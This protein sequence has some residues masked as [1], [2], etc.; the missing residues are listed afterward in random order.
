MKRYKF[1][2]A[3]S[4]LLVSSS[5]IAEV[6]PISTTVDGY[7]TRGVEMFERENYLGCI[8]QLTFAQGMAITDKLAEKSALYIAMA[9]YQL[10]SSL[11]EVLLEG[12]IADYPYSL[13]KSIAQFYLGNC[14]FY[15][16]KFGEAAVNYLTVNGDMLTQAERMDM[17][18][19]LGYSLLRIGESAEAGTY[20]QR[21]ANSTKYKDVSIFY[22]AYLDYLNKDYTTALDKFNRVN[23]NSPL[24]LDS[25][26]YTTQIY[27]LQGDYSKALTYGTSM[28]ERESGSNM[29]RA[30]MHRVVG[31]SEYQLGN[32]TNA[33][34]NIQ[35]YLSTTEGDEERSA[36]YL[37]GVLNFR[38]MDYQATIDN[39]AKVTSEDGDAM[40]QSAYVFIGQSYLKLEKM[41][42]ASIA[43]EKAFNIS[44]D[45]Q[46]QEIAFYNYALSQQAGGRTPFNKAVE[47][48]EQ[49]RK[50]FPDSKYNAEIDEYIAN[51]YMNDKDYASAFASI[52]K[53]DNP[54]ENVLKVK[55]YIM[56]K[57]AI[58]SATNGD[59]DRALE[60]FNGVKKL[61]AQNPTLANETNL[62]IG[63]IAYANDEYAKAEGCYI[64]YLKSAIDSNKAI[65]Y[66]NLGYVQYQ[67]KD[68]AA[69]R[70]SF[71]NAV[72]A[73][74]KLPAAETADANNRIGDCCYY[75]Q[76]YSL[77]YSYYT[78]GA[79]SDKAGDY[80]LYQMAIIDGLQKKH[81][82]KIKG[83]DKML[84]R[85]PESTLAPKALLEQA[86]A[87]IALNKGVEGINVF[88]KVVTNYPSTIEA[89]KAMLQL[90]ITAKNVGDETTA[91]KY[92][93][94]VISEYP[95]SDEAAVAI[96]D[97][98]IIYA[99]KNNID[100]LNSFLTQVPN[101]PSISVTEAD[102]LTF[103]A[104]EKSYI[105]NPKEITKLKE[106]VADFKNGAFVANAQYYIA[107]YN[108]TNSDYDEALKGINIVLSMAKDASFAED[109]L[110]M[111]CEIL[112]KSGDTQELLK[113]YKELEV[114]ASTNDNRIVA[115]LGVMR[116]AKIM[117]Y[118]QD[119]VD[120]TT[121]LL[122]FSGLTA[123]E[124]KEVYM[125]RA[126]SYISLDQKSK[127]IE[128]LSKLA[129]ETQSIYGV[130]GAYTLAELSFDEQDYDK[131]EAQL[132][133]IINK[134]TPHQYWLARSFILLSDVYSAKGNS[135]EAKE[136]LESLKSNY[137][138]N[139]TEIFSMIEERLT[140]LK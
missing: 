11:K 27:F 20:F 18:F 28:L 115:N 64:Q 39:M 83:I 2:V 109:A 19:R 47:I 24:S 26:Y 12:F 6:S 138:G 123:D 126:L 131:A 21:I 57:L 136:Y 56:Y 68:Y 42:S 100:E 130:K 55:Q 112:T 95:S 76:E 54:S 96:E 118:N 25:R 34:E 92:Y 84:E 15:K 98:K 17:N 29:M 4:L 23:S 91:I 77:A 81:A 121:K 32:D 35:S 103:L 110:A 99:E 33:M 90:A 75:T 85:F 70:K 41:N 53:I 128:D 7:V 71:Y 48:F 59:N 31:E 113:L 120:S 94:E 111:K 114:K 38:R 134:G 60:L 125:N 97:L 117:D 65:A 104:A 73:K 66:Y 127:A 10:G 51:V 87:Y 124:E 102:K 16:G 30:E 106:Y 9:E 108:Y 5:A 13:N 135:F 132:D 88:R 50:N 74:V 93:K 44:Y 129:Q 45:K 79:D 37:L 14:Y 8:D 107:K 119:V 67:Q 58:Q 62:W 137:P 1:F 36:L 140:A 49:F 61:S 43:F 40:T 3:A 139:E 89:R 52:S 122:A 69:A 22:L 101:A 105:E 86:N 82:E 78:K 80:A 72:N 116:T 46:A 133:N 63:D